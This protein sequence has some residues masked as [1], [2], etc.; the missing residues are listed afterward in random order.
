M[1]SQSKRDG[2]KVLPRFRALGI[3]GQ[4][5]VE[6]HQ[7]GQVFWAFWRGCAGE[8]IKHGGLGLERSW[9]YMQSARA[10]LTRNGLTVTH[11][12]GAGICNVMCHQ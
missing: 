12:R 8:A 4:N 3:K 5:R 6:M 11:V 1:C 7:R 2:T 10:V 9:G